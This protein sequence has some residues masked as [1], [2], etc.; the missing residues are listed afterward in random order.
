MSRSASRVFT[1]LKVQR[2]VAAVT[3]IVADD[4]AV[5]RAS[6]RDLAVIEGVLLAILDSV[7]AE[8]KRRNQ[9]SGTQ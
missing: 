2:F 9:G 5:R 7:T 6:R 4:S 1:R 3:A 8:L